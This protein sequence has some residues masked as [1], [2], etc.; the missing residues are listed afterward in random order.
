MSE[1]KAGKYTIETVAPVPGLHIGYTE[2]GSGINIKGTQDIEDGVNYGW[3]VEPEEGGLCTLKGGDLTV[4]NMDGALTLVSSDVVVLPRN[5]LWQ[6]SFDAAEGDGHFMVKQSVG[7]DGWKAP[8]FDGDQICI[9]ERRLE[10]KDP[11]VGA[12]GSSSN[13]VGDIVSKPKGFKISDLLN[14]EG[15]AD[16]VRLPWEH[17]HREKAPGFKEPYYLKGPEPEDSF[18]GVPSLREGFA[19]PTGY[20]PPEIY[21]GGIFRRDANAEDEGASEEIGTPDLAERG[22][23]EKEPDQQRGSANTNDS[24]APE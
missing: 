20:Q 7:F 3:T 23:S 11:G 21:G 19:V 22:E 1:L 17:R 13:K 2:E 24:Q 16:H 14:P 15:A 4:S 10:F 8:Q 18:R 6:P 9:C 12:A 5:Q